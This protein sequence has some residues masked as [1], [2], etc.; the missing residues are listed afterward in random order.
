L[1]VLFI[2]DIFGNPGRKALKEIISTVKR[3]EE[4]DICICNGENAAGGSGLTYPVAQELFKSGIDGMT[5]GNHTWSKREIVNFI[6]TEKNLVRPANFSEDLPGQGSAVITNKNGSIGIVN[7]Q[8]RVYMDGSDCPFKAA[9]REVEKL[10]KQVKV[11]IV[12]MHAEASSEKC[13]LAWYLDGTVSGVIGTHTHVQT[14]DERILPCG[15]AFITDVGM[16]GPYDGIIGVD[17][18]IIINRFL[19]QM[20][21]KFEVARGRAQFNA[22]VMN[23]DENSGKCIE[24]KRLNKVLQAL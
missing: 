16:T 10:K 12:D 19:T 24:I 22:V 6:D 9:R 23:I 7:V 13:A 8:G 21:E 14:A 20:P 18:D 5:L 4:I 11:V 3:E 1:K 17:K 2:G 15:T